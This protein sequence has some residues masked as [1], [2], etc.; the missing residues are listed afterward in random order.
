[1]KKDAVEGEETESDFSLVLM[2]L[3]I[4]L[5][6]KARKYLILFQC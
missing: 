1:M 6:V 5:Q 2:E 3:L 4:L